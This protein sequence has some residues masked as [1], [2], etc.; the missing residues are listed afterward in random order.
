MFFS[1]F[2]Q[3]PG[4]KRPRILRRRYCKHPVQ[5][6]RHDFC[7]PVIFFVRQHPHNSNNTTAFQRSFHRTAKFFRSVP[8]MGSVNNKKGTIVQHRKSGGPAC[9][10]HTAVHRFI[11][12]LISHAAQSFHG[13]QRK[14]RIAK[15]ILSCQGNLHVFPC[16]IIKTL[17]PDPS[18]A[19]DRPFR[20]CL[21]YRT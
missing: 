20:I 12:N 10:L 14:S 17:T 9:F 5:T 15:L 13:L 2:S 16:F 18:S 19:V 3:N 11:R 8:V 7:H 6:G 21:H 4:R 1:R